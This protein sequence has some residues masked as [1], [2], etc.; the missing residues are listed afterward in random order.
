MELE[1]D[2]ESNYM[3]RVIYKT[4]LIAFI[5]NGNTKDPPYLLENL[6]DITIVTITLYGLHTHTHTQ[7]FT[8]EA[9]TREPCVTVAHVTAL[10]VCAVSIITTGKVTILTLINVCTKHSTSQTRG[11][12]QIRYIQHLTWDSNP[13]HYIMSKML[14][15]LS[16]WLG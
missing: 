10:S 2:I 4:Q 9:I 3:G 5:V 7:T 8:E 15:Q 13:W 6:I 12:F 11:T 14:Y 1:L 16:S